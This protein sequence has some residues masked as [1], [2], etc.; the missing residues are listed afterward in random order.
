MNLIFSLQVPSISGPWLTSV[1]RQI[2]DEDLGNRNISCGTTDSNSMS[3][4]SSLSSNN[5][6]HSN[7]SNSTTEYID[8]LTVAGVG[9]LPPQQLCRTQTFASGAFATVIF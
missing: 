2:R 5:S 8:A 9:F 4:S 3:I 1:Y 7:N 6:T